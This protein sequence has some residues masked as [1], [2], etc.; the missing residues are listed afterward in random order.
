MEMDAKA[1][2]L[3]DFWLGEV[4]PD[5]WYDVDDGRDAAI[6]DRFGGLW[7]EARAGGLV[8]W[9]T[10][11][12]SCLAL[13][14]LLDQFPRNMFRG[15]ARAFATDASALTVAKLAILHGK[16]RQVGLPERQFFYMP[17]QHSELVVNQD[18]SVRLFLLAFGHDG[19]Y[20][21][22]ARAHRAIIRRFGRFPT[23]NACLGR[24]STPEEIAFLQAGGYGTVVAEMAA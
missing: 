3:L 19:Y 10:A 15:D 16:D 7:E 22:H 17:L 14:I 23:R 18:Q 1:Q 5:G 6:R 13:V 20:L 21:N 24:A 12:A 11:T 9:R 8:H 2:E 4:G